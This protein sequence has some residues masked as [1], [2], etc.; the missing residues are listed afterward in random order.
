MYRQTLVTPSNMVFHNKPSTNSRFVTCE[1]IRRAPCRGGS[2]QFL[3][4][5]LVLKLFAFKTIS[6]IFLQRMYLRYLLMKTFIRILSLIFVKISYRR[7]THTSLSTP[8][9]GTT[10]FCPTVTLGLV[11]WN[12][13]R[14]CRLRSPA[15][16]C[17]RLLQV[18]AT[19]VR[20]VFGNADCH[21]TSGCNE[22]ISG[23]KKRGEGVYSFYT[24]LK[25]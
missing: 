17:K 20:A 13:A 19:P 24:S 4:L 8:P 12:A 1:R 14:L 11:H 21:M 23:Y 2:W 18:T 3:K 7:A 22:I 10:A 6:C 9:V 25:Q 5:E 15:C 16:K